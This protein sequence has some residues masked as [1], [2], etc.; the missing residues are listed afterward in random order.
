MASS[1]SK[2]QTL[3]AALEEKCQKIS[4]RF[5]EVQIPHRRTRIRNPI[6]GGSYA[7]TKIIKIRIEKDETYSKKDLEK[8]LKSSHSTPPFSLVEEDEYYYFEET[9]QTKTSGSSG[10]STSEIYSRMMKHSQGGAS[11]GGGSAS[12]GSPLKVVSRNS[13][14]MSKM[15]S[16]GGASSGG[17]SAADMYRL[18]GTPEEALKEIK[19]QKRQILQMLNNTMQTHNKL[20]RFKIIKIDVPSEKVHIPPSVKKVFGYHMPEGST[21][22]IREVQQM[23]PGVK[24]V[25]K[26]NTVYIDKDLKKTDLPTHGGGA[27]T[28]AGVQQKKTPPPKPAKKQVKQVKQQQYDSDEFHQYGHGSYDDYWGDDMA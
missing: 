7:S 25:S 13:P 14:R 27:T 23:F 28:G 17:G 9:P 18:I 16:Q 8:C 22:T 5:Q 19:K 24:F 20:E 12:K 1:S 10:K 2:I 4:K 15:Q 11:S 26:E 3:N 6:T 21:T